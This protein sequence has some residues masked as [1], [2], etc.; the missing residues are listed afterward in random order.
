MLSI[1]ERVA[2]LEAKYEYS[3]ERLNDIADSQKRIEEKLGISGTTNGKQ[4]VTI[5]TIDTRLQ[6]VE[7]HQQLLV[8][9]LMA[10]VI[11]VGAAFIKS[12]FFGG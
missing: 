3:C 9:E 10:L 8:K 2:S 7:R 6:A 12:F 5:A 4:D 11:A 1:E